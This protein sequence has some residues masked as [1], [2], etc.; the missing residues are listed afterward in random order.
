MAIDIYM[1]NIGSNFMLKSWII[2]V[3]HTKI[4]NFTPSVLGLPKFICV[5]SGLDVRRSSLL[6]SCIVFIVLDSFFKS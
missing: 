5:F 2:I 3:W 1:H 6:S 4:P